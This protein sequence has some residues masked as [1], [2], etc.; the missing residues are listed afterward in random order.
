MKGCGGGIG[1]QNAEA[2]N[3]NATI[4]RDKHAGRERCFANVQ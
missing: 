1:R 4:N 3:S 2:E